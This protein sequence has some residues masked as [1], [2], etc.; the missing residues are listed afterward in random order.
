MRVVFDHSGRLKPGESE[1]FDQVLKGR[2]GL[3][4]NAGDNTKGIYQA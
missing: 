4:G 2:P 3:E 1:V